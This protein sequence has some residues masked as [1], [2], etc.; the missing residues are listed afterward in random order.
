M[1]LA[2]VSSS[3]ANPF[4]LR[5]IM[6]LETTQDY[7]HDSFMTYWMTGALNYQVT[8]HL[9]PYVSQGHYRDLAPVIKAYCAKHGVRYIARKNFIDAARA[10]IG[11]LRELGQKPKTQ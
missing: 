8:H 10:H 5:A 4:L 3:S 9:F 1:S 7:G 2:L 6:Q 11:K